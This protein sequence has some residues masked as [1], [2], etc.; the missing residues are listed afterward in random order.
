MIVIFLINMCDSYM[1]IRSNNDHKPK[2]ANLDDNEI[3]TC[4]QENVINLPKYQLV[5]TKADRKNS[6]INTTKV[7]TIAGSYVDFYH[8]FL[9]K[10][11]KYYLF[12]LEPG[13]GTW[14][15][16]FDSNFNFILAPKN[17]YTEQYTPF[18]TCSL[19]DDSYLI[20][21]RYEGTIYGNKY[22]SKD[23]DF[24]KY[25]NTNLVDTNSTPYF[26]CEGT[27]NGGAVLMSRNLFSREMFMHIYD[28]DMKKIKT[29][30]LN[31]DV[32]VKQQDDPRIAISNLNEILAVWEINDG[33]WDINYRLYNY[34]GTAT[35]SITVLNSYTDRL[36]GDPF[37]VSLK[38]GKNAL[39]CWRG[40]VNSSDEH[41]KITCKYFDFL[42]KTW[43]KEFII[44][45]GNF[46]HEQGN[47][48]E[49]KYGDIEMTYRMNSGIYSTSLYLDNIV[50][51]SMSITNSKSKI[52]KLSNNGFVVTWRDEKNKSY[53]QIFN[54]KGSKI[55]GEILTQSEPDNF[56]ECIQV[57]E[58]IICASYFSNDDKNNLK[59]K[60]F[61]L[62]G[63]NQKTGSYNTSKIRDIAIHE[64]NNILLVI[65][66]F[67]N[68][69]DQTI[70]RFDQNLVELSSFTY[71]INGLSSTK[72]AFCK[73]NSKILIVVIDSNYTLKGFVFNHDHTDQKIYSQI[74]TLSSVT[75]DCT[76]IGSKFY[77]VWY[78]NDKIFLSII[79][80]DAKKIGGPP[81]PGGKR[82][83]PG[84]L[85]FEL[86]SLK[87]TYFGILSLTNQF[88]IHYQSS[89]Y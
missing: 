67:L 19:S 6:I 22:S 26:N 62:K 40:I 16:I 65:T 68:V 87:Y 46:T 60:S 38:G 50:A 18:V 49:S 39:V 48:I 30:N 42:T 77:I 15:T 59:L 56:C 23:D 11:E 76:G 1:E 80:E 43:Q 29:I 20:V 88:L 31:V 44:N 47:L 28:K 79:D 71:N 8:F 53:F 61:D 13:F 52:N 81:I 58:L 82:G 55:N 63:D 70:R 10:N 3:I 51:I 64:L 33:S 74:N 5:C 69:N 7:I 66:S 86:I 34:S 89:V 12:W 78:S 37:L 9:K 25:V 2:S 73:T 4:Y 75:A 72:P 21:Y 32:N 24:N 57:G 14:A 36:Q 35:T 85:N 84:G 83:Q 17:I 54:E 27:N 45:N 41:W